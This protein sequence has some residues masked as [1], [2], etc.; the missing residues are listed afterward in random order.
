MQEVK[1]ALDQTRKEIGNRYDFKGV[2]FE[3]ELDEKGKKITIVASTDYQ[4]DA[5]YDTF[6]TKA[7]R[8]E[9]SIN[10]FEIAPLVDVGGGRRKGVVTIKDTL[11][12]EDAKK[13]VKAIKEEKLKVQATIQGESVR[14]VGKSLD[15]LQEAMASVKKMDLNL[16]LSFGNYR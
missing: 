8:R 14:V 12:S 2:N 10:A 15:D 7:I 3:A 5:L 6:Q 16:P 1:N 11:T 13:I 4:V 9:L